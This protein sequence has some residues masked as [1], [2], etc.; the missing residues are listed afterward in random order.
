MNIKSVIDILESELRKHSEHLEI[1]ICGGA[2]IQLLGYNNR[3][4][5]DIDV[6]VPTIPEHLQPLIKSIANTHQ[7]AE[8]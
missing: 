1:T 8:D 7:L 4:T 6:I 3:P 5:K 2:A